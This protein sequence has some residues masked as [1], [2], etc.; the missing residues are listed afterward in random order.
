M[1]RLCCRVSRSVRKSEGALESKE[2]LVQQ[3]ES[4][5]ST[6]AIRKHRLRGLCDW[7]EE[8]FF[9]CVCKR[10]VAIRTHGSSEI[11]RH[12]G[13][14]G[15]W[16]RDV[17]YRVHMGMPVYNKLLEPMTLSETQMAEHQARP[18]EDHGGGGIL[19]SGG[20]VG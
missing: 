19:L 13:S 1:V 2:A 6:D 18:F 10:D 15:H 8:H 7:V 11:I 9:C 5:E 17:T 4:P 3:A 14:A 12:F 16:R 20:S